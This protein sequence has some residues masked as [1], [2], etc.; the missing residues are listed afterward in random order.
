MANFSDYFR[1]SYS[2]TRRYHDP[3]ILIHNNQRYIITHFYF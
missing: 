1:I 3:N 2:I